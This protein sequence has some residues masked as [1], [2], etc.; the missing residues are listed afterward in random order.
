MEISPVPIEPPGTTTK[1]NDDEPDT[2][3]DAQSFSTM[4]DIV[5][6][7]KFVF[8]NICESKNFRFSF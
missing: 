2:P 8:Q 7:E 5:D 4:T 3:R 6:E 1:D